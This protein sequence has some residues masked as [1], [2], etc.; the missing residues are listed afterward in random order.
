MGYDTIHVLGDQSL[1]VYSMH[2]FLPYNFHLDMGSSVNFNSPSGVPTY[3]GGHIF[4]GGLA[5][6]SGGAV[7]P[8][9]LG[10]EPALEA[11]QEITLEG[12]NPILNA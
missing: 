2:G 12:S 6:F 9:G 8:N 11:L 7:L 4:G 10:F 3:V 5:T 1:T